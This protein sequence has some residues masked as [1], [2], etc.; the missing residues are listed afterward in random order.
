VVHDEKG[1]IQFQCDWEPADPPDVPPELIEWR[2]RLHRMGLIGVYPDGIGFGNVSVR[3]GA[4]SSLDE[5]LRQNAQSQI[6]SF[7]ISGTATGHLPSLSPEHFAEVTAFDIAANWL[8]CRG[9]VKASSESLSHAAVYRS[10]PSARAVIHV[11]HLG[12]WE[13]HRDRLPTTDHAAEA[14]TP[15]MAGAIESLLR[16]D[17][18][19]RAGLF[20]MG[21]HREGIMSFGP[22]LEEAGGRLLQ[23]HRSAK[24][25]ESES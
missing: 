13:H 4:V 7:F 11:H 14:G 12:L 8:R 18:V 23:L 2:D 5:S 15:Q 24:P 9:A 22:T 6:T 3:G 20:I 16:D 21:G 10:D 25:A 1:Y 17:G 19:R